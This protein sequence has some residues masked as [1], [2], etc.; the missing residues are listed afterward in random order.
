MPGEVGLYIPCYN[1]EK[2]LGVCI[3]AVLGQSFRLKEVVVIDDGST[4][5]TAQVAGQYPVRVISHS[6]NKGL[7][8][9]RNTAINNIHTD[10]IASVDADCV[11][12]KEWLSNLMV[13]FADSRIAGVG[14]ML[15]ETYTNSICDLWRSVH[16]K[17]YWERDEKE[18]P[19]LFGSNTVFRKKFLDDIGLYNENLRN[20]YEDV[21]LCLRLNK[22]S[23]GFIYEHKA[24]ARHL[25]RDDLTSLLNTY[26]K[27]HL[28]YYMAKN[29]YSDN[30]NFI[31]KIKDNIG[32][33]NRYMEE[34]IQNGY[35]QLLYVDFLLAFHHSMKD[36]GFFIAQQTGDNV[37]E[38]ASDHV[39]LW[40]S[41]IDLTLFYHLD[42]N[43]MSLRSLLSSRD[44]FS[45]NFFAAALMLCMC[46]KETFQDR[47]FCE[48]LGSHLLLSVFSIDDHIL[49]KKL[50]ELVNNH[51]DW[52]G[53]FT[54][55][56]PNLNG[57]FL[58]NLYNDL[59]NWLASLAYN[60]AGIAGSLLISAKNTCV[61]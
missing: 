15:S 19:F 46:V 42:S 35:E 12:E 60:H 39:F 26:W 23:Y 57:S 40:L 22:A 13:H 41:L 10:Y 11:P 47:A 30:K 25:K 31:L 8:A 21:D 37:T 27:W 29:F 61:S 6:F 45:Q 38:F 58:E 28:T 2:T 52:K 59:H 4:D 48:L 36:L 24:I 1:T 20:N 32:L 49:S 33:A 14:G 56:H 54:K 44:T 18:P 17:Q 43:E 55:Q 53:L 9:A 5:S 3:E 50:C 51:P 34:D 7:A 16:M